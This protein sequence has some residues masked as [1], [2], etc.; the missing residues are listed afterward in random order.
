MKQ[1]FLIIIL[2]ISNEAF[3]G[4]NF[5]NEQIIYLIL[6]NTQEYAIHNSQHQREYS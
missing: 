6:K 5:S 4:Q 2:F 1:I 3:A